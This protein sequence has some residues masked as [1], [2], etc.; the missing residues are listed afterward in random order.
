MDFVASTIVGLALAGLG[1][2]LV[3]ILL[4]IFIDK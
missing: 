4:Y 2:A 1:F 3:Y